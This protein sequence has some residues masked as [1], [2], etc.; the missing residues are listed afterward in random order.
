MSP[1]ALDSVELPS[2]DHVLP[3]SVALPPVADGAAAFRELALQREVARLTAERNS[4]RAT[5]ATHGLVTGEG[6]TVVTP[7]HEQVYA[8]RLAAKDKLISELYRSTS[9][10][11]TA[12][13]RRVVSW[14]RR[15]PLT[16]PMAAIGATDGPL[17]AVSSNLAA[18]PGFEHITRRHPEQNSQGCLLIVADHL[19]LFDQESEG[20][21]LRTLVGLVAA[22]GWTVTFGS[23][24]PE[25]GPGVLATARGRARYEQGLR[26]V[27]VT[28]FVY[29]LDGI[30]VWLQRAGGSIR[31]AMVSFPAVASDVIPLVRT[32]CPWARVVF[33][34]VDLHFLRVGR[35]A[36]L[37]GTPRLREEARRLRQMELACVAMADVTLAISEAERAILLDLM[38][39]AVVETMPNIFIGPHHP[40]PGPQARSGLLFVGGFWH[41]PDADAV[42]WFV[43]EIWPVLRQQNPDLR[44]CIAGSNPTDAVREL[45]GRDG[46]EVLGYVPDLTSC[47][48]RARV[49]V[50]PLRFGAGMMGRVGQS[51]I[52]GLPVVATVIGAEGLGAEDGEHLLVAH[53]A[54]AF[55]AQVRRLL[56]DDDSW[57][58]IQAEGRAL[59]EATLSEAAVAPRVAALFHV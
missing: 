33:D 25:A 54:E 52:C 15:R 18:Y 41:K 24:C 59:I 32:Y 6:R 26:D 20:L 30:R 14:L 58:R 42:L 57:T 51:M 28:T 43:A 39:Q 37:H 10:R 53:T 27:G 12:P 8:A 11:V 38:P 50:A 9:W 55:A 56:D 13:L 29:G 16:N 48:D 49:F 45:D 36:E 1:D 17:F 40:P 47:F 34:T 7:L 19:P 5:L 21:R 22:L 44:F 4:L 46:I 3:L 2:A 23:H 35:E 31:F